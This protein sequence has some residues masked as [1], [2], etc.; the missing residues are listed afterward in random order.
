MSKHCFNQVKLGIIAIMTALTFFACNKDEEQAFPRLR[1]D[2]FDV[3]I[4]ADTAVQTITL[5]NGRTFPLNEGHTVKAQAADTIIRCYGQLEIAADSSYVTIYSI[6]PA[7]CFAPTPRNFYKPEVYYKNPVNIVT[8]YKARHYI[9]AIVACKMSG[10]KE[11]AF[12]FVKDSISINTLTQNKTMHLTLF[13]WK[14]EE[15]QE[16][17][18]QKQYMSAPMDE[19][20]YEADERFDSVALHIFTYDGIKVFTYE[21]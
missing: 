19:S 6:Y 1:A 21:K 14:A 17:Y 18:S 16:G 5:D 8:V 20:H 2:F 13:H 10:I 12:D 3:Y 4:D 11:H 9:N 7:Q 15:E